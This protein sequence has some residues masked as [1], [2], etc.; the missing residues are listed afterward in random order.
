[1]QDAFQSVDLRRLQ[2]DT[3]QLIRLVLSQTGRLEVELDPGERVV[4]ISKRE[5]DSLEEALGLLARH[6]HAERLCRAV[7][8]ATGSLPVSGGV[9]IPA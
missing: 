6:S 5:L 9:A 8:A 7:V 3:E 4:L 2:Q 1:M